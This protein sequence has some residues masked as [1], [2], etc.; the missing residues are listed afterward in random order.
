MNILFLGECFE[1]HL[2]KLMGRDPT[3]A[4]AYC[5]HV[6]DFISCRID[7]SSEAP[8]SLVFIADVVQA[9]IESFLQDRHRSGKNKERFDALMHY[10][11]FLVYSELLTSN[12]MAN[13]D[14]YQWI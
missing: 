9:D 3:V 1:L 4:S 11:Q 8:N 2:Q 14:P 10:F 5:R 12:P 13:I 7:P 6:E